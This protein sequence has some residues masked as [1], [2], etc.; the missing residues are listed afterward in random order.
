MGRLIFITGG[1]RSG[2]SSFALD[3]ASKSGGMRAYVA[4]A[5]ALDEEMRTRIEDHRRE[6]GDGWDTFEE[7]N[8]LA[9][10]VRRLKGRYGVLLIDCL[11]LWLSNVMLS[12]MDVE[13]E[14]DAL[15]GAL[16]EARAAMDIYVVSN[17]VGM[18]IV[19]D[20]EAARRF[21]DLAGA[22]NRKVAG[23]A[24]EVYL[25]VAGIPVRIKPER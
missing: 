16:G 14:G 15:L 8:G 18:G 19:P 12:G 24:D 3:A 6:R 5:Q 1:A 7:P 20:N 13:E 10:A 17:E 11:T 22:L 21:R 4:T 2:K 25:T 9:D 23:A